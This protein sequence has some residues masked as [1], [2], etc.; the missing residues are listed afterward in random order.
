MSFSVMN[1]EYM[2]NTWAQGSSTWALGTNG[3]SHHYWTRFTVQTDATGCS[4]LYLLMRMT[5]QQGAATS[6]YNA[7]AQLIVSTSNQPSSYYG[8]SANITATY[9]GNNQNYWNFEGTVNV[10]MAA[11]TTYYIF[12]LPCWQDIDKF[13]AVRESPTIYATASWPTYTLSMSQGI[14]TD[15]NVYRSASPAGAAIGYLGNGSAIY[16]G[17]TLTFN[18]SAQTGYNLASATLNGYSVSSGYSWTVGSNASVVTTATV[19]S[20]SLSIS[21]GTGSTI[22]VDRTSSPKAGAATGVLPNGATIY[23]SDV[24]TITFTASPGYAL[25]SHTVNGSTFVSGGSYTVT[26][27]VSVASTAVLQVF[28]LSISAG[29]NSSITVTRN[30]VELYNGDS[31][32]AGDVLTISF[33]ADTGYAIT[34]HTVNGTTFT[35]GGTHTVSGAVSVVSAAVV[36]SFALSISVNTGAVISVNRTSSPKQGAAIGPVADG[37]TIYYDDVLSITFSSQTGYNLTSKTINGVQQSSTSVSHTVVSAVAAAATAV[38]QSFVLT[39]LAQTGGH[40]SVTRTSSPKQ[41]AATGALQ[42]GDTVYYSDT[43]D[44]VFT[45]DTGYTISSRTINGAAQPATVTGF[46]VI[47]AV[48]AQVGAN[49][50]PY[51]LTVTKSSSGVTVTVFRTSSPIGGGAS[52]TLLSGAT[53]YYN[54]ELVITYSTSVGYEL[55]DH[56]L[57]GVDFESGDTHTVAGNVTV[58]VTATATGF[59]YIANVPYLVYVDNGSSWDRLL[60][61]ID[62]GSSWDDY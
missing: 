9:L 49:P 51:T 14:G 54:D 3:P 40:V 47:S 62:N 25:T 29:A 37:A 56:T 41:G 30:G 6:V 4:Q 53:I 28:T 32:T 17:D 2:D 10:S 13:G 23:Y 18:Y 1:W 52:E 43:L 27:A 19:Q 11:N 24:L 50:T 5:M 58:V 20:F 31:I 60:S 33:A 46:T 34:T 7:G 22:T 36:Q 45:A 48:A 12:V 15:M 39:L 59:V 26:G 8:S 44:F 57:N 42:N 35:S 16:Q 55:E 21:A 61:R 38:V